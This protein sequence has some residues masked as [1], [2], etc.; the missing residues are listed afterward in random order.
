MNLLRVA[1]IPALLV[2]S[3]GMTVG[4]DVA[5]DVDKGATKTGHVAKYAG[6]KA[7]HATK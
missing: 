1:G 6:K 7:V 2:L 4:Q 3:V 5:H